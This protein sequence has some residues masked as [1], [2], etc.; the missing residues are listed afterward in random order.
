MIVL[1]YPPGNNVYYRHFKG[2]TVLSKEGKVFKDSAAW[3][4]KAAGMKVLDGDVELYMILHPRSNK[5][6]SASKSRLDLDGA[7]KAVCDALN[8][9]GYH[10][11]KQITR[12]VAE[13]GE[14]MFGG[15]VSV[16]VR[17]IQ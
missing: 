5:D 3:T 1:P 2:I 11:D 13:V 7:L 6:G 12:I 17:N 9:V 15:G 10:D 4:C 16:Q 14:P 8:G